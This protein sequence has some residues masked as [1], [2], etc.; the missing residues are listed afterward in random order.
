MRAT[1]GPCWR[2]RPTGSSSATG[3]DRRWGALA[4]KDLSS[5]SRSRTAPEPL[6]AASPRS[7]A[8]GA[9]RSLR[10]SGPRWRERRSH[11]PRSHGRHCRRGR[12]LGFA[13]AERSDAGRLVL[14]ACA[15][16]LEL[17]VLP[18]PVTRA[19]PGKAVAPGGLEHRGGDAGAVEAEGGKKV[20]RAAVGE[21]GRRDPKD[22]VAG[23]E[24]A[25]PGCFG[26]G[27]RDEVGAGPPK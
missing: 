22:E 4:R 13:E 8:P 6:A 3:S 27:E 7:W 11:G 20:V 17:P 5:P 18:E 14:P 16:R 26:L 24:T 12:P 1:Y 15:W 19:G 23:A 10:A 21:V 9:A 2:R 25:R